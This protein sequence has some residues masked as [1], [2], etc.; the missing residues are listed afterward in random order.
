MEKQLEAKG[1]MAFPGTGKTADC[2][3]EKARLR[4]ELAEAKE[5]IEI[6]K[7]AAAYFARDLR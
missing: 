5:E 1:E 6:L 4:K 3:P 7:K 2:D